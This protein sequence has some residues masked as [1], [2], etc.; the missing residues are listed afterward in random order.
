MGG[1]VKGEKYCRIERGREGGR[2]KKRKEEE[3]DKETERDKEEERDT[4][5][6]W[7]KETWVESEM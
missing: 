3:R 7:E 1:N 4:E 2:E 6:G 5:G